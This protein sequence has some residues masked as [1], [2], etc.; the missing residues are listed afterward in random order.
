MLEEIYRTHGHLLLATNPANGR[1]LLYCSIPK[2]GNTSLKTF[3]LGLDKRHIGKYTDDSMHYYIRTAMGL[4]RLLNQK[5]VNAS[6]I[7]KTF[8]V[9]FVR[10][11]FERLVSFFLD[12]GRR[13]TKTGDHYYYKYWNKAMAKARGGKVDTKKDVIKFSEFV[14]IILTT[15]PAT[16]DLHWQLYSDRCKPCWVNYNYIGTLDDL[17]KMNELIGAK[18]ELNLWENKGP[19][20]TN[21]ATLVLFSQLPKSTVMKLYRIYYP[22][23]LMFGFPIDDYLSVAKSE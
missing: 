2:V 20:N 16:Y 9:M 23:F 18:E 13:N 6:T 8:K 10:H 11:P 17:H 4:P 1:R 21:N 5:R 12:K 3:L 15:E 19:S 22:D 7:N 14:D